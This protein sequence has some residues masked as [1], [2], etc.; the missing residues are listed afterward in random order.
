[1]GDTVLMRFRFRNTGNHSLVIRHIQTDC[2]CSNS[3]GPGQPV[4]PGDTGSIRLVFDTRKSITGSF[5]K[6]VQVTAN[7]QPKDHFLLRYQGLITGHK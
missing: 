6:Q 7:T 4:L 5:F 3:T 2:S 1:M